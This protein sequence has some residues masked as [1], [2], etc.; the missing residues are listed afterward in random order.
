MSY[1]TGKSIGRITKVKGYERSV[2]VVLEG[3]FTEEITGKKPVFLE[4]EGRPVPF[5]VTW[6]DYRGGNIIRLNLDGCESLENIDDLKGCRVL[7]EPA[8]KEADRD[9]DLKKLNGFRIITPDK[10]LEAVIR[11]IIDNPGQ[12]LIKAQTKDGK[13]L[14]IPLHEDLIVSK[15]KKRKLIIMKLPEGLAEIN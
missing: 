14:L 4:T 15:D 6:A 11:G 8:D 13:E 1:K 2:T 7:L 10:S 12:L 5:F 9:K 3:S